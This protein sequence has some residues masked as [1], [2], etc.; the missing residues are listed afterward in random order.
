MVRQGEKAPVDRIRTFQRAVQANKRCADCVERGPTYVCLDFHT[1]VCQTCSGIHREFGHKIKGISLSDW[2]PSEVA[3]IEAGGNE[4]AAQKWLARLNR[5]AQP[6]PD[7]SDLE[8][9]RDFIKLKYVDKR[10]LTDHL[11]ATPQKAPPE[12]VP[13]PPQQPAV[14][15]RPGG[16]DLLSD[17]GSCP[18]PVVPPPSVL[19]SYTAPVDANVIVAPS[20]DDCGAQWTADFSSVNDT[21]IPGPAANAEGLIDLDFCD[22]STCTAAPCATDACSPSSP[23]VSSAKPQD[24]ELVPASKSPVAEPAEEPAPKG[25]SPQRSTEATEGREPTLGDQ[26]REAVLHGS[27]DDVMRLYREASA[28]APRRSSLPPDVARERVAAFAAFDE[29]DDRSTPESGRPASPPSLPTSPPFLPD[30]PPAAGP[31]LPPVPPLPRGAAA[32]PR[33][34]SAPEMLTLQQLEMLMPQQCGMLTPQQVEQMSPQELVQMQLMIQTALKVRTQA[35]APLPPASGSGAVQQ[36]PVTA[37]AAAAEQP[38]SPPKQF[39]DLIAA[40]TE[41]HPIAGLSIQA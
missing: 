39:G 9:L 20:S 34:H 31:A 30:A 16:G 35:A 13:A 7:N 6:E 19:H 18:P 23:K 12:P 36:Q 17:C 11:E 2:T 8:K 1:F 32:E 38:P 40:F 21:I 14:P 33:R 15:F 10:W 24:I 37:V 28:P 22:N 5:E 26:L 27:T 29:L 3:A 4:R 41:K 25:Q